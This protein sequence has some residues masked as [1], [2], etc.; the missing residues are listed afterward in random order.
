[1][2]ATV[3]ERAALLL[4]LRERSVANHVSCEVLVPFQ[5]VADR[6]EQ[7]AVA[8]HVLERHVSVKRSM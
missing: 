1:V 6:R 5:E 3:S 4:V 7:P 2:L 8:V